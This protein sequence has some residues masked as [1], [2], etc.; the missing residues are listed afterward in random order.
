MYQ[1]PSAGAPGGQRE[2]RRRHFRPDG[3]PYISSFGP[4]IWLSV[5]LTFVSP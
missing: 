1:C 4:F 2:L 3:Q 5:S